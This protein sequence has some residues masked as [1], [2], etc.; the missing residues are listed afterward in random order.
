MML[1]IPRPSR[2]PSTS[3]RTREFLLTM[4]KKLA[5][6]VLQTRDLPQLDVIEL[7]LT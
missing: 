4:T 5:H 3:H 7:M 1:A 6:I 2:D